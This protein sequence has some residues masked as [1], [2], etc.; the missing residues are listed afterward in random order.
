MR[1]EKIIEKAKAES[2]DFGRYAEV[3]LEEIPDMSLPVLRDCYKHRAT[4]GEF[5]ATIARHRVAAKAPKG[6]ARCTKN[7]SACGAEAGCARATTTTFGA[8]TFRAMP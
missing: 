5:R 6:G 2:K 8:Q 7:S 4:A 1:P 3:M